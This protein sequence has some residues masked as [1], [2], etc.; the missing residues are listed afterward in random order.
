MEII[1]PR[2]RAR[3]ARVPL[4]MNVLD[5][6]GVPRVVGLKEV[7]QSFLDHRREVL[8]RTT[9]FRLAEIARR[10]EAPRAA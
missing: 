7:L 2:H 4:N 8:Q 10:T 1:V 9:R 3:E 5:A 6:Q